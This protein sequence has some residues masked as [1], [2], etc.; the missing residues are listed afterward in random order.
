[1]NTHRRSILGTSLAVLAGA[2]FALTAPLSASAHVSASANSTA[3]GSYTIVTISVP[4]GVEEESTSIVTIE[5]PGSIAGVTPTV[6]PNWTLT[7]TRDGERVAE[8]VYTAIGAG[9]PT[10]QRDTFELSL[11]LPE[12]QPG[13]VVEFRTTQTSPTGA[14]VVWEDDDVPSVVLTAAG[15]DDGHSPGA[16]NDHKHSDGVTAER[17]ITGEVVAISAPIGATDTL[18]RALGG[19]G[20]LLGAIALA[21]SVITRR[22]ALAS[23]GSNSPTSTS[24]DSK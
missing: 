7:K 1:M 12:G 11:Q 9:L 14:T 5:I 24:G 3:A 6:N 13:D 4:H 22:T 15:A 17:I 10:D 21:V 2:S 18:G 20:M 23:A 8:V 16:G 19:A